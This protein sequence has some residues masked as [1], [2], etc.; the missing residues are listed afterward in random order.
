MMRISYHG[1]EHTRTSQNPTFPPRHVLLHAVAVSGSQYDKEEESYLDFFGDGVD[2]AQ[3][4]LVLGRDSPIMAMTNV[5]PCQITPTLQPVGSGN[6][7]HLELSCQNESAPGGGCITSSQLRSEVY[8]VVNMFMSNMMSPENLSHFLKLQ[9]E[10]MLDAA[11]E[12]LVCPHVEDT[13]QKSLAEASFQVEESLRQ[14]MPNCD[15]AV[16]SF[17]SLPPQ[18]FQRNLTFAEFDFEV[19]VR[20]PAGSFWNVFEKLL[21]SKS[22]E[23]VMV[24]VQ[25]HTCNALPVADFSQEALQVANILKD[26]AKNI[27]G[28]SKTE[29]MSFAILVESIR[30]GVEVV[31]AMSTGGAW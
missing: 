23:Q 5:S 27:S 8:S 24:A 7:F 6:T 11:P 12:M 15:L 18:Q 28:I 16:L 26:V 10:P 22:Q 25:A 9:V 3:A 14:K 20:L 31:M 19:T 17:W 2:G 29:V 21:S 13:L 30:E 4:A 1:L